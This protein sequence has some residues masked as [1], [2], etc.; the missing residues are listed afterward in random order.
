MSNP[1][2]RLL[3]HTQRK[4]FKAMFGLDLEM[5]QAVQE[6]AVE[7]ERR[8]ILLAKGIQAV[9]DMSGGDGWVELV[10][11]SIKL[12]DAKTSHL[13]EICEVH[14]NAIS[15]VMDE[16]TDPQEVLELTNWQFAGPAKN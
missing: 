11:S 8:T 2:T 12:L 14:N 9:E 5:I 6:H 16:M 15:Q 1:I 13:E 10:Q 3:R 7:L 4:L